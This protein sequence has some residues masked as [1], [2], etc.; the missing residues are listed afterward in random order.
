MD[1][2]RG[3][4]WMT[5]A[6]LGFAI[7]DSFIKTM[8]AVLPTWQI[9]LFLG[10]GGTIVFGL[11]TARARRP[12][13]C[14][15]M[16]ALPVLLRNL[17]ELIG[18]LGFVTALALSE[19][20]SASAILQ[21]APLVVTLG[22]A[23]FLGEPVG[24]RRWS[25]IC[26]GFLGVLLIVQPGASGF[27]LNALYA[28]AAV[29]GLAIRDLATRRVAAAL[30]SRQLS[31]LAFL[32]AIPAEGILAAAS[33]TAWVTPPGWVWA[34]LPVTVGIGGV[35]Y[36][37]LIQATRIGEISFVTPFRYTRII[38]AL[39]AGFAVFGERPDGLMLLGTLIIIGSGLYT[40]WRERRV[41]TAA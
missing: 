3:A 21:A 26:V 12:M 27:D 36:A 24:W 35:A 11:L 9:I 29:I 16:L 31:F 5:I 6:M 20:S 7:E 1:N 25:A 39:V 37:T 22:A 30:G 28:V 23:L 14:R 33:D 8:T 4:L 32:T 18:I 15:D 19:L 38:F 2:L 40:F 13:W 17:G 41:R 10:T 34:I